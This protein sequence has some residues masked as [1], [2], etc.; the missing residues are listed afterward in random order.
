MEIYGVDGYIIEYRVSPVGGK[1]LP[2][3]R[4]YNVV[5]DD[6]YAGID[7]LSIDRLQ[8]VIIKK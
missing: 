8:A 1:Y 7:G 5:N 6:G 2:F 4:D 3:V